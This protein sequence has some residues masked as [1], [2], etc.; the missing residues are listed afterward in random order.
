LGKSGRDQCQSAIIGIHHIGMSVSDLRASLEFYTRALGISAEQLMP[1]QNDNGVSACGSSSKSARLAFP[2]G[3]LKVSEYDR[4]HLPSATVVPVMGPGIT[5][6]CYQSPTQ[7]NIY[8]RLMDSGATPVSRGTEPVHLLGQGVYYA[9]ARDRDGI[10]YET[11]HLDRSP[12]EGPIW[13]SHVALVSPD[14]D[15]LVEFYGL[16]LNAE[17]NR[18]TNRA[19]GPPFDEVADYDD[20]MIR[21]AWFDIGNMILEMWQFVNPVTPEVKQN[22]AFEALGYNKVAFEV[23]DLEKEVERLSDQGI[24]FLAPLGMS[25]DGLEV[26]LRDPDGNLI[27][28]IQPHGETG[29]SVGQLKQKTW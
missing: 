13:F 11:E 4:S 8:Q 18:R 29:L 3:Y 28:L 2:N 25:D 26:C 17:P 27:S 21:A 9:Y 10:M 20:V 12:F 19:S 16:L 7:E 15:R 1:S 5:H 14:L 6:V 23:S 22:Q 24:E